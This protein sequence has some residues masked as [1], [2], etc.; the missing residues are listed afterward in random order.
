MRS[1]FVYDWQFQINNLSIT[2]Q[3]DAALAWLRRCIAATGGKGAAHSYSPIWGWSKAYPETTGYLIPTLLRYAEIKQDDSLRQLAQQCQY[4]LCPLQLPGG[5]FPGGLLG[6]T[7]PSVFN[8]AMILF[9]LS[10]PVKKIL[11][12]ENK[13]K[14]FKASDSA[15]NWLLET[16][17]ADGAWRQAAY[18][19]GFIPSYY[20]YAVWRVL[21]SGQALNRPGMEEKMRQALHFYARRFQPDGTVMDW[22]FRPGQRAFTHTIAYTLQGFL[23]SA[24][25]LGEAE[26]L[27]K[28]IFASAEL[29]REY[30]R[31]GRLAGRYSAGWKGDYSFTCPTGNAQLS[32]LY[33]RLWETTGQKEYQTAAHCFFQEA[34]RYQNLGDRPDTYGALPGSAP[35]WGPYLRFRYPN[36]GGKFFLDAADLTQTKSQ[37]G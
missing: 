34:A 6:N 28:C 10:I 18:V 14:E 4:W 9:G 21:Q 25:V 24:L 27:E 15:L 29:L 30:K 22:G 35:F 12:E 3:T 26:I 7:Q 36:W 11:A 2:A 19:P 32:L 13:S 33:Y 17:D 20:S 1:R 5:A 37:S 31:A 23:E 8:T 16:L